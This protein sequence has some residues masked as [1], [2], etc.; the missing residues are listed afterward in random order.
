[1]RKAG[2]EVILNNHIKLAFEKPFKWGEHDCALWMGKVVR[3]ISG[4]DT[5]SQ[6]EGLY[7]TKTKAYEL[8]KPYGGILGL[9]DNHPDLIPVDVKMAQRGDIVYE[10]KSKAVGIC[11]GAKCAFITQ[12]GLVFLEMFEIKKAWGVR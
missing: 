1:M 11:V 9:L 7:S 2:W 10:A 12:G 3:D 4:I 8:L 6:F 5:V